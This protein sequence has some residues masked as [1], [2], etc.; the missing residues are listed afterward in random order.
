[1]GHKFTLT[2]WQ[3]HRLRELVHN[4]R[5]ARLYRRALALKQ[6]G[7]GRPVTHVAQMLGIRRQTLYNWVEAF[8]LHGIGGLR[9]RPGR[10]RKSSWT[11]DLEGRLNAALEKSPEAFGY[12]PTEWTV[13]L[14][15]E[16]LAQEGGPKLSDRT[17]RRELRRLS[18]V[19]KRP[20]YVLAPDPARE[21]KTLDSRHPLPP[22]ERA[23][24]GV[25]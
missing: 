9:D 3:K 24:G 15:Q 8:E 13:P 2:S 19:W 25:V 7:E 5:D 20:R 1:M 16:H 11:E 17:L 23:V 6:L 12:L 18:Y 4:P 10:G 22:R 21:K 14:L